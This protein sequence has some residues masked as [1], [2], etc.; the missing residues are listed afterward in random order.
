MTVQNILDYLQTFAPTYMKY[1]WDNVGLLCGSRQKEVKKILVALDPFM[2]VCQEAAAVGADLIVTHHPLIFRP[3]K[4]VTDDDHVGKSI[5]FL[6]SHGI[7]AVNAHTNLDCAPG[8]VNDVLAK[9]LGLSDIEMI[10]PIGENYGLLRKGSIAPHSLE[11]FMAHVKEKLGTPVLRYVDAGREVRCVA[12]GGGSCG[13]EFEAAYRAGC[14]TLVT[15][16]VKYNHFWDA[17]ELG[18]NLI[19]A[20]HY[21]TENPITAVLAEKLRTAFPEAEVILSAHKDCMQFF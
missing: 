3:C 13:D 17:K 7:A 21:Y 11:T 8:G 9:T 16:D 19:D 6:L 12:V 4:A 5:L 10:D 2:D 15:A 20:G 14:D 18:I 1:D